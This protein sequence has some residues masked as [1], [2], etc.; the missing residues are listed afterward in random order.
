MVN[1][2]SVTELVAGLIY[3]RTKSWLG[4]NERMRTNGPSPGSFVSTM[5]ELRSNAST[6]IKMRKR[7]GF[8]QFAA[9]AAF[10]QNAGNIP[11]AIT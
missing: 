4:R 10:A 7:A 1:A 8:Y 9:V 11:P 2:M 6:R 3:W 5:P